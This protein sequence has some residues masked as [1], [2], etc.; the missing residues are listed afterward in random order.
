MET[1]ANRPPALES[2]TDLDASASNW[3]ASL[4]F[5]ADM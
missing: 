1:P 5:F 4:L 2:A 3:A